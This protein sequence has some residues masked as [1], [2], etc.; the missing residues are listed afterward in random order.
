MRL[1]SL[2]GLQ[3]ADK[4][5]RIHALEVDIHDDERRVEL[6]LLQYVML[7]L[8][9]GDAQTGAFRGFI[10]LDGKEQVFEYGQDFLGFHLGGGNPN[11]TM[12]K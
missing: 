9:E 10:D 6:G 2:V 4:R 7:T 3:L 12:Q 1:V 11:A 8:D 5:E